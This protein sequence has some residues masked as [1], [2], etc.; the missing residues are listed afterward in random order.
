MKS[1]V[2]KAIRLTKAFYFLL[3]TETEKAKSQ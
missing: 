2:K 1:C 3:K